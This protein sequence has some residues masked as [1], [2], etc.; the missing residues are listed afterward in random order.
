MVVGL[1]DTVGGRALASVAKKPLSAP[2]S[3]IPGFPSSDLPEFPSPFPAD[4]PPLF[5][6][7]ARGSLR[8]V[9]IDENSLIVFHCCVWVVF[10][11]F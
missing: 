5:E 4:F 9:E 3:Q 1:D 11:L 7:K 10:R 8:D 2:S 6:T